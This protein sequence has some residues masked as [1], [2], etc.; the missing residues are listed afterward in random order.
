MSSAAS[1]SALRLIAALTDGRAGAAGE[2]RAG[3]EL[4]DRRATRVSASA[5]SRLD[6]LAVAQDHEANVAAYVRRHG[7][8]MQPGARD[9]TALFEQA[10]AIAASDGDA[11]QELA[12]ID[13]ADWMRAALSD[14]WAMDRGRRAV[15]AV[16]CPQCLCE[17]LLAVPSARGAGEW[18]AACRN[19]W[20]GSA[21]GPRTFSLLEV[22]RHGLREGTARAS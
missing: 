20:C 18:M 21:R 15:T 13:L 1:S 16:S 7:G 12:A 10:G 19:A 22:A 9:R 5:P 6:L 17:S 8:E 11:A 3:V 4:G 2:A 14:M